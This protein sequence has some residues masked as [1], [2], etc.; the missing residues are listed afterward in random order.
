MDRFLCHLFDGVK[1][2]LGG[3]FLQIL[4]AFH[5]VKDDLLIFWLLGESLVFFLYGFELVEI[6]F[7]LL[8]FLHEVQ[9]LLLTP[10]VAFEGLFVFKGIF[11]SQLPVVNLILVLFGVLVGEFVDPVGGFEV[12]LVKLLLKLGDELVFG[13]YFSHEMV[14]EEMKVMLHGFL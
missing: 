10:P 3:S 4:Q 11:F 5:L 13:G 9:E 7:D 14:D 2:G 12:G 6:A 1:K 8:H